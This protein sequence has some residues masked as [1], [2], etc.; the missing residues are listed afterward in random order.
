M[1]DAA[2]IQITAQEF[3]ALEETNQIRELID[4]EIVV[5]PPKLPHQ[6][7]VR[8]ALRLL[9]TVIPSGELWVAPTGVYFDELNIPE[10]DIFWVSAENTSCVA[11]AEN[12]YLHGAPDLIIEILS[13]STARNDK[14]TKFQL[15]E[16]YGVREYWIVD[17]V[18]QRVEVW[19]HDGESFI[20]LGGFSVRKNFTSKALGTEIN[21][22]KLL[23]G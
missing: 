9:E 15:Y 8:L 10:P 4:G 22:D 17:S 20:Y 7:S 16:K 23:N 21:V 11:N 19:N 13:P 1:T 6:R 2:K 14:V 3:F 5:N 18:E 12:S